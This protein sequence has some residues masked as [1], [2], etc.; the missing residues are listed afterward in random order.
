[1]TAPSP[2]HPPALGPPTPSTFSDSQSTAATQQTQTQ[3]QRTQSSTLPSLARAPGLALALGE[4]QPTQQAWSGSGIPGLGRLGQTRSAPPPAATA[5]DDN[6]GTGPASLASAGAGGSHS[7]EWSVAGDWK[8]P[9]AFPGARSR[10]ES[11]LQAGERWV[12][13]CLAPP[14]LSW[15]RSLSAASRHSGR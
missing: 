15:P 7:A 13:A 3:T 9:S 11:S 6:D 14:S 4:S 1:M 5:D 10:M 12:S 8:P 2:A